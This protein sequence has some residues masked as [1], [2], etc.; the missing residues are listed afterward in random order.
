MTE[1]QFNHPKWKKRLEVAAVAVAVVIEGTV[2]YRSNRPLIGSIRPKVEKGLVSIH[3]FVIGKTDQ[4]RIKLK[5]YT[6]RHTERH[7]STKK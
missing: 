4:C 5:F 1:N 2:A 3:L 7:T 6:T